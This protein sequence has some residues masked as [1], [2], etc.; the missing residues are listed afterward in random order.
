MFMKKL[1]CIVLSL[2][3]VL[4][5]ST[6]VL[7]QSLKDN[8]GDAIEN[9]ENKVKTPYLESYEVNSE[10]IKKNDNVNA[11]IVIIDPNITESIVISDGYIK[12]SETS[13]FEF[14]YKS[15]E[16][17]GNKVTYSEQDSGGKIEIKIDNI[18]YTGENHRLSFTYG[19]NM[20]GSAYKNVMS[21]DVMETMPNTGAIEENKN[22]VEDCND[23]KVLEAQQWL[24]RTYAGKKGFSP[25]PED[26]KPGVILSQT[27]VS[28]LQ[29]ELGISDPTGTFG[30][31]T[32]A[33]FDSQVGTLRIG[34]KDQG[35]NFVRLLQHALFCKGYSP[36]AVTGEFGEG[37]AGAV[38]SLKADAGISTSDESVNSMWYKAIL[39]SDAYKL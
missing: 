32:K 35:K 12:N 28:A 39:N 22:I 21:F 13:G 9:T 25:V 31:V 33:A 4:G 2:V 8:N 38:R 29:I 16:F 6:M 23:Q 15:A 36:T 7:A 27:F 10:N 34:S 26:G 3:I 24:N 1:I 17:E 5:A 18:R 37:T 30:D 11:S 19:F 14:S 20:N